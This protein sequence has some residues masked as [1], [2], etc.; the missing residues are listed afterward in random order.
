M[1]EYVMTAE[2]VM[3]TDSGTDNRGRKQEE[4]M[5]VSRI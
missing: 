1:E 3:N 5:T 2:V 4:M